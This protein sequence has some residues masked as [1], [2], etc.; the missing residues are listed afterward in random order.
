MK[1]GLY[2]NYSEPMAGFAQEIG[3]RSMQLSAWPS[4]SLNADHVTDDRLSEIRKDLAERDIEI[5]ALG[6]YPN[7]LDVDPEKATE[8]RRYLLKVIELAARMEVPTVAT[9]AGQTQGRSVSECLPDFA[10]IYKPICEHA[11]EHGVRLAIENC[12]IRDHRTGHGENIAYSPE[13][14]EAMF[15][16]VPSPALGLQLD[17]SHLCYLGIDYIARRPG[18]RPQDLP[19]PRQGCRDRLSQAGAGRHVRAG[20]R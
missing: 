4:S 19:R 15:E 9:F 11:E 1:L 17:P 7:P 12:P 3:F 2:T 14:W 20:P 8:A 18:L 10:E 6:Y 5:S 13:I 16:L